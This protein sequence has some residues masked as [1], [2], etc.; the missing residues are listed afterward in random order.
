MYPSL[1]LRFL[2]SVSLCPLFASSSLLLPVTR[3]KSSNPST[4]NHLISI[5][6]FRFSFTSP[7]PTSLTRRSSRISPSLHLPFNFFVCSQTIPKT[8][9]KT[10]TW[11]CGPKTQEAEGLSLLFMFYSL[12]TSFFLPLRIFFSPSLAFHLRFSRPLFSS[13]FSIRIYSNIAFIG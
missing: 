12:Y 1:F 4:N 6:F 9:F 10:Y 8:I 11:L 5:V 13:F 3:L 2:L 7:P